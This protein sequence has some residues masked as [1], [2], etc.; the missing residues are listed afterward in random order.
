MSKSKRFLLL[1]SLGLAL[2]A[3]LMFTSAT[4]GS[5]AAFA[6]GCNSTATGSWSNNCQTSQGNISLFTVAIQTVVTFSGTGC[7]THGIDGNFGSNTFN[8]VKCFQGKHHLAQ[9]GIVGPKTWTALEG[10]LRCTGNPP[11]A[12]QCNLPGNSTTL[13]LGANAGAGIWSVSFQGTFRAMVDNS[14]S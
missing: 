2:L 6:A 12:L 7:T 11:R 1:G 8:G 13:F 9:D 5:R 4:S 14:L 3:G 10:T